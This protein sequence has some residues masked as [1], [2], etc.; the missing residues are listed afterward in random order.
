MDALVWVAA[1]CSLVVGFVLGVAA[2]WYVNRKPRAAALSAVASA[3]DELARTAQLLAGAQA[4]V[5]EL[6]DRVAEERLRGSEDQSVLHALA[7]VAEQL[8]Q[9]RAQVSVL[10][11]DR[12]EQFGQLSEQL[13]HAAANDAELL[14]TTG[15]LAAAL[16]NNAVRGT[17]G[18]AQLRRVV[19]AAGMLAHVDFSEQM[20]TV[21]GLRPDMVVRLPGN[22]L[23][24]LDAKVP[25][26][27]YLKAQ[28]LSASLDAH[29]RARAKESM[30]EHAKALRL[31]VD[32]LA[33]KSYWNAVAGSPELV[34]CFL[35]AESFL[36]DALAADPAL[37]D[38]AFGKNV[39]LASP[40]TLLA[41]LKGL[42]F[43]WRQELLTENAR[44]LFVRSRELYER[45]GTM[46]GHVAKLG[47]SLRSSVE[48]YNA[49]VGTLESR[50]LPSARRIR[51][52]DPGLGDEHDPAAALH[53]LPVIEATPR[54]LGAGEFLEH[55]DA[56]AQKDSAW[57]VARDAAGDMLADGADDGFGDGRVDGPVPALTRR[58]A[59]KGQAG[60]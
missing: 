17:W 40:A 37:L 16:G 5:L 59:K 55:L 35:P 52:L 44:E 56:G 3:R 28:Q 6:R 10:E 26:A 24:V 50:V 13:V 21:E 41:M 34:V 1:L 25:L 48:R 22:K 7:P 33:A 20:R 45:L 29:S 32:A 57:E 51:D 47:S 31:H 58:E 4:Q 14:R 42:A 8:R 15:S 30:K 46:G 36:A 49:F 2:W 60:G 11:R 38:Y 18:E 39:A 19:E 9:V 27:A 43:A 23:I 12:V 53:G 54:A